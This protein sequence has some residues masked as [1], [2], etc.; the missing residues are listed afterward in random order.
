MRDVS[1]RGRSVWCSTEIIISDWAFPR[2]NGVDSGC[3]GKSFLNILKYPHQNLV[4]TE[5]PLLLSF[6]CQW[7]KSS[8]WVKVPRTHSYWSDK[9]SEQESRFSHSLFIVLSTMSHWFHTPFVNLTCLDY[10]KTRNS[11][12][13]NQKIFSP[14]TREI[15]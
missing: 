8:W 11:L 9:E 5:Q 15:I 1:K 2:T 7:R 3:Y 13:W 12:I 4:K 10:K 6:L 14:C